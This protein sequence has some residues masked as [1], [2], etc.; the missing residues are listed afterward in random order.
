MQFSINADNPKRDSKSIDEQHQSENK[1][2]FN[3]LIENSA[4]KLRQIFYQNPVNNSLSSSK[5]AGVDL[6]K[7]IKTVI[8]EDE[9]SRIYAAIVRAQKRVDTKKIKKLF[10]IRDLH[11]IPFDKVEGIIGYPAGGVPPF[12]FSAEFVIDLDLDDSEIVF[13]GGGSIFT[14]IEIEVREIR[15]ISKARRVQIT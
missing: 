15:R 3:E 13:A 7:I 5:E 8:F 6:F 2:T 1:T 9:K 14:L 11:L 10:G 12:G 4:V